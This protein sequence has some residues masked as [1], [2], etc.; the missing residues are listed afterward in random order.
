MYLLFVRCI[1]DIH[2]HIDKHR[3]V[4]WRQRRLDSPPEDTQHR[5]FVRDTGCV[6]GDR[7]CDRHKVGG[8]LRVHGIVLYTGIASYH[9]QGRVPAESLI[10]IAD[11]IAETD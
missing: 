7:S 9:E 1:E 5:V 8:H 4:W 10:K 3:T 6:L 2:G 11:S